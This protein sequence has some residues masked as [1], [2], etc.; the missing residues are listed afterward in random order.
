M[1]SA[2]NKK[3]LKEIEDKILEV[4]SLSEGNILED[5]TAIKIL[6]SSKLLSEEISEKQEIASVTE[7]QIDET[8][9]GYQPVAVHSATIF[10]CISDLVH[11]ETMYQYSLTWFINLYVHSL[12]H[13]RRSEELELRIEYIIEHFTLSIYNNVCRSLFEKDKLLFSFLLTIGIMKE[14]KQIKKK[15]GLD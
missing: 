3:Q 7:M 5:E 1:E 13:S 12:A 11:I 2:K 8:R 6:S 4:L 9:M 15:P 10:F 14:K